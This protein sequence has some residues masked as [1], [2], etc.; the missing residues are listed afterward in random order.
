[1]VSGVQRPRHAAPRRGDRL[2]ALVRGAVVVALAVPSVV[3]VAAVVNAR[4]GSG[5]ARV[6]AAGTGAG[7]PA[8]H[9]PPGGGSPAS[10]PSPAAWAFP[11]SSPA[12]AARSA[13]RVAVPA[14]LRPAPVAG[15]STVPV[16]RVVGLGD[17]VP[18]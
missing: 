7:S 15:G 18:A 12:A 6:A 16:A 2:R 1:M 4:S 13:D 17:S 11:R 3:G 5:G 14:A 10:T 8:G 9:L